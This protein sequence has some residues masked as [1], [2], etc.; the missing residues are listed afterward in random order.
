QHYHPYYAQSTAVNG[1]HP[2][3]AAPAANAYP[4]FSSYQYLAPQAGYP[5][6]AG[7]YSAYPH[8]PVAAA[9]PSGAANVYD[10]SA[11]TF[12]Y[13]SSSAYFPQASVAA[14]FPSSQSYPAAAALLS[15]VGP[16]S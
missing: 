8:A 3:Y 7:G 15:S 5:A 10:S 16:P 4:P 1:Y 9:A 13:P 14:A 2:S 12:A 6:V 11:S